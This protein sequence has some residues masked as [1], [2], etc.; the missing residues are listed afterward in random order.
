MATP[1]S[2]AHILYTFSGGMPGG[3]IWN[4][5]LRTAAVSTVSE[6]DLFA[7]AGQ[8]GQDFISATTAAPNGLFRLNPTTLTFTSVVARHVTALGVTDVQGAAA[9]FSQAGYAAGQLQPN[10]TALVATLLT[11]K[12]GRSGKGRIYLPMLALG[13]LLDDRMT[14]ATQSD[15]AQQMSGFLS[16]MNQISTPTAGPFRIAVQ[17]RKGAG[18]PAPVTGVSIGDV[19]DTQ[20]RRR[21]KVKENYQ[22][23]SV[24]GPIA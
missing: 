14:G 20:R 19:L 2:S 22:I 6:E 12:A 17:S 18:I 23:R 5:G 4:F 15:L 9:N 16:A 3:D 11:P 10:Q 1:F 21:N 24:S 8:A 13:G 7:M